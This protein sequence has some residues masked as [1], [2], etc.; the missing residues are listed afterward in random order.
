MDGEEQR[1]EVSLPE[2]GDAF[3]S[4]QLLGH[5][6]PKDAK[7]EEPLGDCMSCMAVCA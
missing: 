7:E 6:D 1:A 2:N 4:Q 3:V 5:K